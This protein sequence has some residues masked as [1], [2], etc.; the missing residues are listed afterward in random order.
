MSSPSLPSSSESTGPL[1]QLC[2]QWLGDVWER[3]GLEGEAVQERERTAATVRNLI[4][5]RPVSSTSALFKI[6]VFMGPSHFLGPVT[7]FDLTTQLLVEI[8]VLLF[9]KPSVSMFGREP[10]FE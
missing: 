5:P 1:S 4:S 3:M 9:E 10:S 6:T 7:E 2:R 8:I